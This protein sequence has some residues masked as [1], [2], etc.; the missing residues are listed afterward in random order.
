MTSC[1]HFYVFSFILMWLSST[2]GC[3]VATTSFEFS[4]FIRTI[5]NTSATPATSPS[6]VQVCKSFNMNWGW[7]HQDLMVDVTVL[8]CK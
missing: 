7:R 4:T 8:T 2:L 6:H 1:L 5:S 3:F